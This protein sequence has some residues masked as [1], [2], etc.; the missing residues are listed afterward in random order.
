MNMKNKSRFQ[1]L[2]KEMAKV[3]N[4]MEEYRKDCSCTDCKVKRMRRESD[5]PEL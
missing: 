1:K 3:Y 5:Y 4:A 2:M